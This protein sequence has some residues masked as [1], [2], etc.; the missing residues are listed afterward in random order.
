[1]NGLGLWTKA[2]DKVRRAR[3]K[4]QRKSSRGESLLS[5]KE[6]TSGSGESAAVH[7][8]LLSLFSLSDDAGKG[9]DDPAV[10]STVE[11]LAVTGSDG[12]VIKQEKEARSSGGVP[13]R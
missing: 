1:M 11:M 10:V 6:P 4:A 2:F 13:S 3:L 5:V 8:A 9:D 12:P 7:H